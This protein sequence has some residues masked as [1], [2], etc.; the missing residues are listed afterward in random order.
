M[1]QMELIPITD[2]EKATHG[3]SWWAGSWECR[4]FHGFFQSREDGRGPWAF[5]IYGFG[6]TTASIYRISETGDLVQHSV[7]IDAEDRITVLGRKYGRE[8]WNH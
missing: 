3:I 6:E 1:E 7:P 2:L 8:N 4:N 5:T